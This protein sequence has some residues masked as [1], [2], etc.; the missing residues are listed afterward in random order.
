LNNEVTRLIDKRNKQVKIYIYILALTICIVYVCPLA[1][2]PYAN[3]TAW[4]SSSMSI[5]SHVPD[6]KIMGE[7]CLYNLSSFIIFLKKMYPNL[8]SVNLWY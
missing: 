2:P 4:I 1:V 5:S 7:F 8:K 3:G 6:L